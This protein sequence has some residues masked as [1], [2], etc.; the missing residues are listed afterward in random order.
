MQG[1]YRRSQR[2]RRWMRRDPVAQRKRHL[3]CAACDMDER[4]GIGRRRQRSDDGG[5]VGDGQIVHGD[6]EEHPS[7]GVLVWR[8]AAHGGDQGVVEIGMRKERW[9]SPQ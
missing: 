1:G 5:E 2:L 4:N 6:G 3:P 7:H 9:F 8:M